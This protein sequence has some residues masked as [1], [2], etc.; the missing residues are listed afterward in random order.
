MKILINKR[1]INVKIC[2][3]LFSKIKG[4]MFSRKKNLLFI[5]NKDTK[6][7]FHTFFVFFP[8][9]LIL[10]DKNK[11]ILEIK[12]LYPFTFYFPNI[13][14]RYALELIKDYKFNSGVKLKF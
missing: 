9:Y 11:K 1:I 12:K 3:T 2:K 6:I 4:L 8:I 13:K 5:F 7:N 14:F 10:L